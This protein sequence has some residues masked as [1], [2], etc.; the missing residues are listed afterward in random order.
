M[1]PIATFLDF[2]FV[3]FDGFFELLVFFVDFDFDAV[4]FMMNLV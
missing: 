1:E 3:F 2:F 4:F